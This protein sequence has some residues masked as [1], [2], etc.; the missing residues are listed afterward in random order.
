MH[1][2]EPDSHGAN[3]FQARTKDSRRGGVYLLSL[4]HTPYFVEDGDRPEMQ[5]GS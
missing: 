5:V 3:E 1:F 2:R 4:F